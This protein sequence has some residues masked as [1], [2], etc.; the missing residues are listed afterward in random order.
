VGLVVALL[1]F[2]WASSSRGL[3]SSND[4]SHVA[5]ARA[6]AAGRSHIDPDVALTLQ[7]DL[8]AHGG[9]HRS[10]RP[11]G[12]AFVAALPLRIGAAFD[13]A[14][15]ER[16]KAA[17][18]LVL[19]P[20]SDPY[21]LTY[22]QRSPGAPP[23]AR[24]IGTA[25]AAVLCAMTLGL[26]GL[27]GLDR[28]LSRLGCT[29]TARLAA[30]LTMGIATTW[31][32]YATTSFAHVTSA[33]A[34]AWLCWALVGMRDPSSPRW[35]PFFAGCVGAFAVATDYLLVLAVVPL[36]LASMRPR[37]FVGLTVGALPLALAVAAYH[38]FAFGHPLSVG[39]DH[40]VHFEFARS[41][42]TTFDGS[43][44]QGAWILLGAGRGAG[45]L[46][47][48]PIAWIGLV[49]LGLLDDRAL[50]LRLG[51][52]WLPWLVVLCMHHTPWGGATED[53]RYLVPL[54]PLV[55]VGIGLAWAR[56]RSSLPI[57]GA[58]LG[59]AGWSAFRSWSHFLA[60]HEAPWFG[61]WGFGAVVGLAFGAIFGVSTYLR[62]RV[63]APHEPASAT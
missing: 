58:L 20:G 15:F 39:Y 49:S 13:D 44:L 43:P 19:P 35:V 27:L 29:P 2:F 52:P 60:W 26:L 18:R 14:L 37:H 56:A 57:A 40:H 46:V 33:A 41:R 4:G 11:P 45:L 28:L 62:G 8:A 24:R 51:L 54:F 50:A 3:L 55:G 10:D 17:R 42:A 9:H 34:M 36:V 16:S 59:L 47:L 31:G 1:A 23:L 5:L 6:F 30:V 38:T 21:I 61:L 48:C 7:V 32:C 12:T 53:H 25:T 63:E 22:A